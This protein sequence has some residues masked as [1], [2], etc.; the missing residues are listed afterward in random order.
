MNL[1]SIV[2]RYAKI[3]P[4]V[5]DYDPP[6]EPCC[7]QVCEAEPVPDYG[8]LANAINIIRLHGGRIVFDAAVGV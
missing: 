5:V 2:N 6:C 8:S 3:E 1:K 4:Q 7:D